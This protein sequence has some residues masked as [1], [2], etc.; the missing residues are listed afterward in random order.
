VDDAQALASQMRVF[1]AEP[2]PFLM[3]A[4]KLQA[5]VAERFTVDKMT[6]AVIDFYIARLAAA[7]YEKQAQEAS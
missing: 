2:Q 5:R 4:A 3:R 7:P 1:L 6:Q